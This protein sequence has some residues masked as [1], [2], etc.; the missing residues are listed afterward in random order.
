VTALSPHAK[1]LAITGGGVLVL[2][3]DALLLRLLEVDAW[4]TI[5][6]RSLLMALALAAVLALWSRGRVWRPF[7]A[8]GRWGLL[9]SVFYGVSATFFVYSINHTDVAHTLIIL[10]ATPLV[11]ALGSRALLKERVAPETWIATI[12][13][14]GGIALVV[15]E[16]FGRGTLGGDLAAF[17]V[18][19]AQAG[20]FI[21]LRHRKAVNMV[22]ATALGGLWSALAVLLLGLAAPASL[23]GDDVAIMA[24]LGL[25][26]VPLAFGLITIGPR[27]I[28]APEVGLL[29]LVETILGPLWVWWVLGE[30]VGA[31]ALLGGGIVIVTLAVYFTLRLRRQGGGCP[32]AAVT[33]VG[34]PRPG[35]GP[36]PPARPGP[37]SGS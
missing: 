14:L 25:V 35:D 4:T 37:R 31:L 2:S 5:F 32:A 3:P 27:F 36:P 33:P 30:A 29:F 24:V 20:N 26:V 15:A 34:T 12:L 23:R 22:P 8:V 11:A 7:R 13:T 10:A 21:T 18:V 28:T 1:G 19:L 16:S 9:S 6:W 17:L